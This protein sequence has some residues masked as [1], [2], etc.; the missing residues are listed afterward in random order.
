MMLLKR[1]SGETEN[2]GIVVDV[3]NGIVKY[4]TTLLNL[5]YDAMA[6]AVGV[7]SSLAVGDWHS[8]GLAY[9]WIWFRIY[10]RCRYGYTKRGIQCIQQYSRCG[11][12]RI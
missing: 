4:N 7:L 3:F 8:A 12:S 1:F 6:A 5:W 11:T 9:G 10:R 2:A